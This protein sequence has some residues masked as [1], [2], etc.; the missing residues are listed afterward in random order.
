M[1]S[2]ENSVDWLNELL[3]IPF[4][5]NI[6][7]KKVTTCG[8]VISRELKKM[9]RPTAEARK[10]KR[11][12]QLTKKDQSAILKLNRLVLESY[13]A[14]LTP[15]TPKDYSRRYTLNTV[16]EAIKEIAKREGF[17]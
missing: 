9:I 17:I 15:K 12:S 4:L 7:S 1:K 6:V 10:M 16:K 13:Y 5:Y 2:Q 14:D 11:Y 3:E 8:D